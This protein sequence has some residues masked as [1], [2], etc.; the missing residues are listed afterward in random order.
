MF[1]H[2]TD[3]IME[4]GAAIAKDRTEDIAPEFYR[5][6]SVTH[7]TVCKEI[8]TYCTGNTSNQ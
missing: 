2:S 8:A 1:D 3:L 4:T 5:C 7:H 6:N